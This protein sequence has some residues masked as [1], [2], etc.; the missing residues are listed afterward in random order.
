MTVII[1][2]NTTIP[3][4][5]TQILSNFSDN[6]TS[7]LVEIYEGEN[8]LTNNTYKLGSFSLDGIPSMKR[9]QAQIE[10]TFDLD[11]NYMLYVTAVEK[12]SGKKKA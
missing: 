9:G 4:K 8:L 12:S 5:K 6:Q 11:A 1:P 2:R 10:I 7:F 3:S